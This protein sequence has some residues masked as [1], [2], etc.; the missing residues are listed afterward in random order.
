[1]KKVYA[2]VKCGTESEHYLKQCP[3][4]G[5]TM[6]LRTKVVDS[7]IEKEDCAGLREVR[8]VVIESCFELL[9]PKM[10]VEVFVELNRR[11]SKN[12]A[13]VF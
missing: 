4:C 2:C 3:R 13:K 9:P 10:Q 1:M 12:I 8:K 7:K 6:V 5:S 11:L